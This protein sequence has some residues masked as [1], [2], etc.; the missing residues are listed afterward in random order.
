MLFRSPLAEAVTAARSNTYDFIRRQMTWFRG[1]DDG[2]IWLDAET[3]A[4]GA[5][6]TGLR[7]WLEE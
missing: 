6:I 2:I 5:I 7:A 4:P 3:L 1:H